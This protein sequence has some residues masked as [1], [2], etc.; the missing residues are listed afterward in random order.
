[1]HALWGLDVIGDQESV[2]HC[3]LNSLTEQ[4]LLNGKCSHFILKSRNNLGNVCN[5]FSSLGI[6]WENVPILF[7]SLGITW[8]NVPFFFPILGITRISIHSVFPK[9]E[10]KRKHSVFPKNNNNNNNN[11]N[12]NNNNNN[13]NNKKADTYNINLA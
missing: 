8:G 4:Q 11:N 2:L 1:M 13:N 9:L 12:D 5:L 6:G 3:R 10:Y 7:S